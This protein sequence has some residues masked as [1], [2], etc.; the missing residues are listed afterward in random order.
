MP[1]KN[2]YRDFFSGSFQVLVISEYY[3]DIV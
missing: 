2:D 3:M 1:D